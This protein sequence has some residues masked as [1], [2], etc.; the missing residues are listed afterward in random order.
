MPRPLT[1]DA[2]IIR[3]GKI[4]LIRRKNDPFRGCFALPGGYVEKGE[5]AKGA[6]IREVEEETG[7]VVR[8]LRMSGVYDSPGR[9]KRGNV[10]IAFLS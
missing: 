6:V 3:N 1:V 9:D 5:D 10:S 7:L 8:P 2:V 4:L